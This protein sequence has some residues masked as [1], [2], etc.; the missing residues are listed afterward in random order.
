MANNGW[1]TGVSANGTDLSTGHFYLRLVRGLIEVA[2][3]RGEDTVIPSATGRVPRNRVADTLRIEAA[4][5][6]M[7]QGMDEATQQ[8]DLRAAMDALRALMDPT[9]AP[10][11]IT[12]TLEDG[13]TR[14]IMAR[15]LNLVPGPDDIPSYRTVSLEWESVS[16]AWTL[17]GS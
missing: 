10:Y 2:E 6:V 16:P 17:V 13:S 15:P 4:G 11:L 14:T 9:L 7:G 5:M 3:V 12:A 1:S 8:A